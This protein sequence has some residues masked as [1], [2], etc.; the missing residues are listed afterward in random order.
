[1]PT[2]TVELFSYNILEDGTTTI[3]GLN[4]GTGL[5]DAGYPEARIYDWSNNLYWKYTSNSDWMYFTC[6]QSS[7]V[8][9]V[10]TLWVSNHNFTDTYCSWEYADD[11]ASWTIGEAWTQTDNTDILKILGS[12]QSKRYWRL[13]VSGAVN[14]QIAELFMGDGTS[15]EIQVSPDPMHTWDSSVIWT[16]SVGGQNYS[17]KLATKKRR[18]EYALRVNDAVLATLDTIIA[19]SNDLAR[20]LL[21]KDLHGDYFLMRFERAPIYRHLNPDLT[22]VD[23]NLVEV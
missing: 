20:P 22:G 1:M 14:P 18:I 7:S 9:D 3:S 19:N 4:N 2:S 10:D 5:E 16:Q 6:D 12:T 23:L 8:S 17:V 11:T 13:T 21:V 15:F